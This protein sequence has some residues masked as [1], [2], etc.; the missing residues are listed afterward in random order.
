MV[1]KLLAERHDRYVDAH[2]AP[3]DLVSIG[4]QDET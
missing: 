2:S 4:P 1:R 3:R